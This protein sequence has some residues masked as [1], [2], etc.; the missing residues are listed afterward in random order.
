[1]RSLEDTIVRHGRRE[2][3]SRCVHAPAHRHGD[4]E[5]RISEADAYLQVM[6]ELVNVSGYSDIFLLK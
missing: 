4:L 1:M 6:I 3:W 2:R 5:R